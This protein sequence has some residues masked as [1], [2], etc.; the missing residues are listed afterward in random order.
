[1]TVPLNRDRLAKLLNLAS[2]DNDAEALNAT[3]AA[4]RLVRAAGMGHL[5]EVLASPGGMS[6]TAM[7]NGLAEMWRAGYET[8]CET[9]TEHAE[10]KRLREMVNDFQRTIE[11]QR[12]EID[13][14]KI[15][16]SADQRFQ[17]GRCE[18]IAEGRAKAKADFAK[19]DAYR[20]GYRDG[21]EAGAES[22]RAATNRAYTRGYADGKAAVDAK[23][24]PT[25]RKA[26]TRTAEVRP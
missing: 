25:R 20:A 7:A 16:K 4:I 9:R 8:G 5:G 1:M 15:K 13:T 6:E 12:L 3:R 10:I 2:S 23:A 26:A 17:D 11:R 14:L 21:M 18:G 22:E 24:K 19:K